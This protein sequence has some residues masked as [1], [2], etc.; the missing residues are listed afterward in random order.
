MQNIITELATAVYISPMISLSKTSPF[1]QQSTSNHYHQIQQP[2]FPENRPRMIHP[3]FS[4]NP[5]PIQRCFPLLYVDLYDSL[6]SGAL[7]K[8][9]GRCCEADCFLIIYSGPLR[10]YFSPRTSRNGL[11]SLVKKLGPWLKSQA[12]LERGQP[13][14]DSEL[15]S[16]EVFF[17]PV[18]LANYFDMP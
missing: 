17:T 18:F 3:S 10:C 2:L 5:A 15:L 9:R 14:G 6:D 7:P 8:L 13:S 4:L 1:R 12:C 16:F 11:H